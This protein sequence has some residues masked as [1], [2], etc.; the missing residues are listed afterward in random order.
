MNPRVAVIGGGWAGCAAALSLAEAGVHTTLFEAG[1]ILG[2]R[3]RRV[4]I[5]GHQLDNG[6][7]I[8]LGVYAQTLSLMAKLHPGDA[9]PVDAVLLRTPLTLEQPPHFSLVCPSLPA[10]FHLLV[11]LW[12]ARGLGFFDKLAASRWVQS[13]LDT[14]EDIVDTSVAQ[15]IANQPKKVRAH[16]WEPLCIA[17]L[18]TQPDQASARIFKH[19][20]AAS[21][22]ES[23]SHSDL[24]FPRL[25]LSRLFPV[26]A[27]KKILELNGEIRL[28]T[29][30]KSLQADRHRVRLLMSCGTLDFDRVVVAVAPQHLAGICAGIPELNNVCGMVGTYRYEV[31]ATVYLQYSR[32]VH[33]SRPM[34]GLSGGP[35]QYVF[36]RGYTHHHPGLLACVISAASSLLGCPQAEW[37]IH[38]QQQLSRIFALPEPLWKKMIVEKQASYSCSPDIQKPENQTPHP[39]VFLAGDYTSGPYPATLESATQSG[40]KSA[41]TLLTNL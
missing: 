39:F 10:P 38:V 13:I 20:L 29:R 3:A 18:N 5:Q 19:V 12:S 9:N 28:Q 14:R 33:L 17:A 34:L 25:D 22:G 41:H 7:H 16:L 26:P 37:L 11:G 8:L 27:A 30:I 4:E 23:R 6:Q 40:V 21:F 2:G 31:I 15:L 35:A 32:D 24:L 36:D 1:K